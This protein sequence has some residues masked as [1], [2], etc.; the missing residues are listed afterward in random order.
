MLC[1][2]VSCM[3][4]E[5]SHAVV[6]AKT[7]SLRTEKPRPD[8]LAGGVKTV[9][10]HRRKPG[11]PPRVKHNSGCSRNGKKATNPATTSVPAPV[12]LP[13]I[14]S[15]A[16]MWHQAWCLPVKYTTR[17]CLMA[18][19]STGGAYSSHTPAPMSLTGNGATVKNS[20]PGQHYW[21]ESHHRTTP[22]STVTGPYTEQSKTAGHTPESNAATSTSATPHTDTSPGHQNCQQTKNSSPYTKPYPRSKTPTKPLPGQQDSFEM[23]RVFFLGVY[24]VFIVAGNWGCCQCSVSTSSGVR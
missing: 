2:H 24:P 1:K 5:I 16:G 13:G 4:L 6:Y 17:S 18:P 19:T 7:S 21:H 12:R 8:E 22:S 15:G 9:A 11:K 23:V 20:P 10:R 3:V 14:L